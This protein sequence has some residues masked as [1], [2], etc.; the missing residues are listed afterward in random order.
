MPSGPSDE[1]TLSEFIWDVAIDSTTIKEKI[2]Y[3]S[4]YPVFYNGR[5]I[6]NNHK[7]GGFTALDM[8]S[9]EKV[10]D[11]RGSANTRQ[12]TNN[13]I[14]E[15]DKSY[16][17]SASR[18][19]VLNL[20]NGIIE[21]NRLWSNSDEHLKNGINIFEGDLYGE[22]GEFGN[23][24]YFSE[25]VVSS[26]NDLSFE[27]W[28]GFDR[29]TP[30]TNGGF[31]RLVGTP[32]FYTMNNGDRLMIY[33]SGEVLPDWSDKHNTIRAFNLDKNHYEWIKTDID[34][35][36]GF[37]RPIAQE[38]NRLYYAMENYYCVDAITGVTVWKVGSESITSDLSFGAGKF[39]YE[40]NLISVARDNQILAL[41]KMTG[42]VIW[43]VTMSNND[44]FY[45]ANGSELNTANI[46]RD[47]LYYISGWGR[48]IS[49]NLEDGSFRQ[50][51]LEERPYIE[52]YD[53]ELFEPTFKG[54]HMII[55][56]DGI[57]YTSDGYRY[58]AFEVPDA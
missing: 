16:Y 43:S 46:Y 30:N 49:M 52:K 25:W 20:Q 34:V 23:S 14:Q 47:R 8:I 56:E 41:D 13:P 42:E 10:W 39:I 24:N 37:N 53:I 17:V 22:I 19:Q 36:G 28:N 44:E 55:S 4:E 45:K 57:I 48:L 18:L 21:V 12:L 5:V 50:Y 6:F 11:N 38:E 2:R 51:Y 27:N 29:S 15:K 3:S 31:R 9:G 26:I 54:Q 35:E 7:L 32:D 1:N 58:L 33:A 40:N